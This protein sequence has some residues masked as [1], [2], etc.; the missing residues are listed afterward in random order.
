MK[1]IHR[2]QLDDKS[3]MTDWIWD[4]FFDTSVQNKNIFL[5]F[6]EDVPIKGRFACDYH[7]L[8]VEPLCNIDDTD[9]LIL[10]RKRIESIDAD[11]Q[12]RVDIHKYFNEGVKM[13]FYFTD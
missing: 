9:F 2:A 13:D 4:E 3:I 1:L 11:E 10:I 12:I 6:I 7:A 8:V 5:G